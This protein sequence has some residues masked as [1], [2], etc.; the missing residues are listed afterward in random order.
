MEA[1][2]E[3]AGLIDSSLAFEMEKLA[4]DV[5]NN[6]EDL[7]ASSDYRE[8]FLNVRVFGVKL[9]KFL[10]LC[11]QRFHDVRCCHLQEQPQLQGGPGP[12]LWLRQRRSQQHDSSSQQ[13]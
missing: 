8:L 6:L 2:K 7:E 11:V 5:L 13:Q 9:V 3:T 10:E 4:E 1:A 12:L